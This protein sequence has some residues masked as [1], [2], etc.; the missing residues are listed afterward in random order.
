MQSLDFSDNAN[1]VIQSWHAIFL[2]MLEKLL[3]LLCTKNESARHNLLALYALL[4]VSDSSMRMVHFMIFAN[5]SAV[6]RKIP[7]MPFIQHLYY[8]LLI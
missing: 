7:I 3:I 5:L 8:L 4:Y 1:N 2:Y 6:N